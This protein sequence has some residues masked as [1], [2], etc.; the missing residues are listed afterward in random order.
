MEETMLL[1]HMLEHIFLPV[2]GVKRSEHFYSAM[3]AP[4]GKAEGWKFEA[5]AGYPSLWGF[6]GKQ[7]GFWLKES[8][9]R[10]RPQ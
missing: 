8:T 9:P 2:T 6:G 4:L 5:K 10:L 7:P 1:D 3:L